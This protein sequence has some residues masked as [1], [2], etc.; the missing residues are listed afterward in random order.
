MNG[1]SNRARILA[2]PGK[3]YSGVE[4]VRGRERSGRYY[5]IDRRAQHFDDHS[6]RS[7]RGHR[8]GRGSGQR[9]TPDCRGAGRIGHFTGFAAELFLVGNFLGLNRAVWI[10]GRESGT[11]ARFWHENS[12]R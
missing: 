2:G 1:P 4:D 10:A 5:R 7:T 6:G 8:D 9:D 11:A 12:G 3:D